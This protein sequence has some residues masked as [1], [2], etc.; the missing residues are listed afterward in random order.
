MR[1]ESK[2]ANGKKSTRQLVDGGAQ[3]EK[4]DDNVY[5]DIRSGNF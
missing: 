1:G 4:N 3:P 2:A 5:E